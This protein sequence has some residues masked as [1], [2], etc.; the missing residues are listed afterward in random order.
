MDDFTAY[1]LYLAIKLHFSQKSYDVFQTRGAVRGISYEAFKKKKEAAWFV[2]LSRKFNNPK[3]F[4]QYLVACAA[5]GSISDVFDYQTSF[6]NYALWL[7]NKQR[8]TRIILDDLDEIEDLSSLINDT[9]PK[10]LRMLIA[11][12]IHVETAV[13]INR[14]KNF[15]DPLLEQDYLIFSREGLRIKKLDRFV[16]YNTDE[17]NRVIQSKIQ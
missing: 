11:D 15:V 13:A 14:Y 7:K 2:G 6:D 1:K 12:R 16:K 17:I 9:P 5:Y 3:E 10:I 4:V 8:T